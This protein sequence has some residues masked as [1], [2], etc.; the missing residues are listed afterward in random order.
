V[1]GPYEFLL[2]ILLPAL[3][4]AG[5]LAVA[6]R[7]GER[8]RSAGASL[9]FG[10]AWFGAYVYWSGGLPAVPGA[11]RTLPAKDWLA[12]VVL[13]ASVPSGKLSLVSRPVLS[14]A[15]AGLSLHILA[16]RSGS[17][18]APVLCAAAILA[19]W[20]LAERW[21]RASDGLRA[22]LALCLS[23]TGTSLASLFAHNSLIAA[24]AG[25]LA[26][27]LGAAAVLSLLVSSFRLRS[28]A[29]AVVALVLCGCLLNDVFFASFSRTG[30]FLL[31]GSVLAPG[32]LELS[33]MGG[34]QPAHRWRY[35]LLAAGLALVPAALAVWI[36]W[37]PGESDYG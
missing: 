6:E 16:E 8:W 25:V 33:P 23:A 24:L 11:D 28:G 9:A 7:G 37:T 2:G 26:A 14:A 22:P 5:L 36:A 17:Y 31:V 1:P 4:C 21:T 35:A 27:C 19:V 29:I 32:L 15:L 20:T 10:L 12:W 34:A 3:L 18:V 30:A 13:V